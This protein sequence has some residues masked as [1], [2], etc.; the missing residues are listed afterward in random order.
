MT[1][2]KEIGILIIIAVI[3]LVAWIYWSP[4]MVPEPLGSGAATSTES[5][6]LDKTVSDGTIT[7]GYPSKE[8]G[9]AA[10]KE[11]I[12]VTAYIP[13]CDENFNYCLYY[14]GSAYEG[15]N[16]ESAGLR[17]KRRDDLKNETSCLTTPPSGYTSINPHVA[18]STGYATSLFPSLGDAGAGHYANG[19]LYR[20]SYRGA[21][22]EFET[23]V[24][25]SQY[26]NYPA[27][28][29]HEFG[30]EG[31]AAVFEM[32]AGILKTIMLPSDTHVA[33]PQ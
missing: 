24:G 23:R 16:F 13:P 8:F 30:A 32:L 14:R 10:S 28:T 21:C 4:R 6:V 3:A 22:Y 31:Q 9:L 25:A 18:S 20:L 1:W 33:F 29:I 26:M 12:L 11:E 5:V 17:I 27:G 7:V 2:R 19:D 15:T